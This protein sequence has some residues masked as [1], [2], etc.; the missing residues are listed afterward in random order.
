MSGW[1]Q[2]TSSSEEEVCMLCRRAG[3]HEDICGPLLGDSGLRIHKFCLYFANGLYELTANQRAVLKFPLDAIRCKIEE[4]EQKH[5][6]VCGEKGASICCAETDCEHSFHLPCATDG[7]CVTHFFGNHRS[8][9][10]DHRPQQIVEAAPEPDTCCVICLEP[11]G[12]QN[13]Y[14]T[15]VCRVCLQAWFHRSCIQGYAISAGILRFRCPVC[16]DRVRFRTEM[17]ILG[18]QIPARR[19]TWEDQESYE[20]LHAPHSCCDVDE[21]QHTEG[22]KQAEEEGPWE[23][24]LCTSCAVQGTHRKCASLSDSTISWECDSCAGVDSGKRQSPVPLGWVEA[25]PG[26]ACSVQLCQSFSAPG[27]MGT[28]PTMGTSCSPSCLSLQPPVPS[29]SLLVPALPARRRRGHQIA[30]QLLTTRNLSPP[31]RQHWSH[32]RVRRCLSAAAC[33]ASPGQDKRKSA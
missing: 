19:P 12:D 31:A 4:A 24:L 15:M 18:I 16:R 20:V 29:H 3:V 8:F 25:R 21:C 33:P 9:C 28:S 27:G 6:F 17:H 7:E 14:H 13:S 1:N 5:C 30:P 2:E 32:L 26:G 10:C 22:R 11:V 23:L